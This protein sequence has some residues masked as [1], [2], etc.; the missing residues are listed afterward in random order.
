MADIAAAGVC[1]GPDTASSDA[2]HPDAARPGTRRRSCRR[3]LWWQLGQPDPH[4]QRRQQAPDHGAQDRNLGRERN[5][6]RLSA[7]GRRS[8]RHA[9]HLGVQRNR[10]GRDSR[11]HRQERD[12]GPARGGESERG[13]RRTHRGQCRNRPLLG[14]RCCGSGYSAS[15]GH[16]SGCSRASRHH[17]GNTVSNCASLRHASWSRA[18]SSRVTRHGPDSQ[19]HSGCCCHASPD[20]AS[21]RQLSHLGPP[22]PLRGRGDGQHG[23][24][25]RERDPGQDPPEG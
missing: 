14:R 2:A 16:S 23:A 11:D 6:Y 20:H 17:S 3:R 25:Q 22:D 8:A 21:S 7:L 18:E 9:D 4:R 1:S 10:G 5:L 19:E 13:R 12:R 15:G 24:R